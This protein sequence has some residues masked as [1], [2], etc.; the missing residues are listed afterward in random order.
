MLSLNFTQFQSIYHP[1]YKKNI[2]NVQ[3]ATSH[4]HGIG[5]IVAQIINFAE[6]N[7]ADKILPHDYKKTCMFGVFGVLRML[8]NCLFYR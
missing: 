3:I 2:H 7:A 4:K 8:K 6:R 5:I 1:I